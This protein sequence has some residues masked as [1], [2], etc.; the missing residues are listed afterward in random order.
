MDTII[1]ANYIE[2]KPKSHDHTWNIINCASLNLFVHHP[3]QP[4]KSGYKCFHYWSWKWKGHTGSLANPSNYHIFK[5]SPWETEI[6]LKQKWVKHINTESL[7]Q[8]RVCAPSGVS[9]DSTNHCCNLSL[10]DVYILVHHR[11]SENKT[12]ECI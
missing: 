4:R 1:T 8:R 10:D 9:L 5:L 12:G 2:F 6:Q 3:F 7:Y 11:E